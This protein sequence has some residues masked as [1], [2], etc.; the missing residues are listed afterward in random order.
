MWVGFGYKEES[1]ATG[2]NGVWY[3]YTCRSDCYYFG[4][5]IFFF[6]NTAYFIV[7]LTG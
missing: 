6:I 1:M 3:V 5:K 2:L 7:S 4:N